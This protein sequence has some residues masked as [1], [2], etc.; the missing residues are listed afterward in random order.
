[1]SPLPGTTPPVQLVVR[2]RLS[3]LFALVRVAALAFGGVPAK[4]QPYG[5]FSSSERQ[6][7]SGPIGLRSGV[8]FID[9]VTRDHLRGTARAAGCSTDLPLRVATSNQGQT[10]EEGPHA[11]SQQSLL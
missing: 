6:F 9:L 3:V 2:L 8:G 4:P 1:M 10:L 11:G 7:L 5:L